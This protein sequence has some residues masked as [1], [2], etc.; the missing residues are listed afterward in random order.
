M[1]RR[2]RRREVLKKKKKLKTTHAH[3]SSLGRFLFSSLLPEAAAAA[4]VSTR[5]SDSG[6]AL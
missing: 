5:P 4:A 3:C 1:R 2:R 6:T